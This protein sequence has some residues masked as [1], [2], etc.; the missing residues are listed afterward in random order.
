MSNIGPLGHNWQATHS[1]IYEYL[2]N[3]ILFG[4]KIDYFTC[5][6]PLV[7]STKNQSIQ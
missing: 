6:Y 3:Y 5:T 1:S 2:L 4:L 7:F